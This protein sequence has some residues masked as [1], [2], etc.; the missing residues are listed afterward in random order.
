MA[1]IDKRIVVLDLQNKGFESGAK[2]SLSTLD[3]LKKSLNF[4]NVG[5]AFSGISKAAGDVDVSGLQS[6]VSKISSGFSSLEVIAISALMN[7]TN[8]AID[9]GIKI[10]KALTVDPI[11]QG[12]GEYELKMGSIQTIMASTGEPL[13]KVNKILN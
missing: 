11:A 12:W 6:S 5:K 1:S 9:A 7:I 8:K 3:R 4:D 13:D 2:T 10:T